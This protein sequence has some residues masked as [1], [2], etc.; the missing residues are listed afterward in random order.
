MLTGN[1]TIRFQ[2]FK[3]FRSISSTPCLLKYQLPTIKPEEE[4]FIVKSP[5][6]DVEIPEVALADYIWRD[7][8]KWEDS[9]ALVIYKT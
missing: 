4:K 2:I 1:Q 3:S 6:P 8:H 7:V 5:Y 9:V